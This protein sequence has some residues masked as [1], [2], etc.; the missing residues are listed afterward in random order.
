MMTVKEQISPENWPPHCAR[1]GKE[2]SAVVWLELSVLTGLY[3][4]PGQIADSNSQGLFPFGA[5][6]A[7]EELKRPVTVQ[8]YPE[9]RRVDDRRRPGADRRTSSM[10]DMIDRLSQAED[11]LQ[12]Y[13]KRIFEEQGLDIDLDISD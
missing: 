8:V 13:I 7:R 6:C 9:R 1:C 2:L 11:D 3:Y 5:T 4:E 10:E 12:A